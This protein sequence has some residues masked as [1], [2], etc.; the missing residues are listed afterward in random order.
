VAQPQS[1]ARITARVFA[2]RSRREL[3]KN[4]ARNIDVLRE[5]AC[6]DINYMNTDENYCRTGKDMGSLV[7]VPVARGLGIV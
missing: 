6:L 2:R 4:R 5:S 1:R 7:R 3:R